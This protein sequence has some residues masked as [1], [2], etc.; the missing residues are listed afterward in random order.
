[1]TTENMNKIEKTR[2]YVAAFNYGVALMND[3]VEPISAFKQ[4]AT[5][6]GIVAYT[7]ET[8]QDLH[9]FVVWACKVLVTA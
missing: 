3:G 7:E 2:K 5:D 4:A 6:C 8:S 9:D 1:M